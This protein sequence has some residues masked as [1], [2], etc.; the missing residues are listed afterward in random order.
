MEEE[1][2][3]VIVAELK[4]PRAGAVAGILFSIL[5]IISVVLLRLSVPDQSG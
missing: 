2:R 5:L 4:A 1:E 3:T